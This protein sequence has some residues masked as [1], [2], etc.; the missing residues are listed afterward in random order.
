MRA[1]VAP[2]AGDPEALRLE[3]RPDPVPGP[4]DALVEVAATAVNRADVMQR[5]GLYPPPEG[6]SDVLGLELA[7]VVAQVGEEVRGVA[8]GDHVMAVV[9]S[10]G[11]AER[12]VVPASTLLPVP[13][14]LGLVEAAALPE[15]FTTA[16]DNLLVRGELAPG[17]TVLVHGGASGVGTAAIQLAVRH[18]ARVLVTASSDH[19]LEACRRLGA[20]TGIDYTRED[21]TERARELTDGIGVNAI[22]DMVGGE[23][24][25]RN[26]RALA[27]DGRLVI[28][29][30]QG[31]A[32]ADLDLARLLRRRL[33][34]R[35]STLRARSVAA[36]A[37]LADAF[38]REVAPGFVD[39][40]LRPVID[41]VLPLD[42]VSEAHRVME[43][44]EHTGKIVLKVGTPV[45]GG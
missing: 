9:A 34:V 15:V 41:R 29:G 39:G 25:D 38:R 28:I 24:L 42:E 37:R 5:R 26:L 30:L 3:H 13:P 11:Y 2:D 8:V 27:D 33:T 10:G 6:A 17:E 36:K 31:G 45:V 16:W 1:V 19:K 14:G 32:N 23:Y 4:S 35:A 18:G 7:G 40:S 22:L 20:E 43:A 12:T 21:F 44:G